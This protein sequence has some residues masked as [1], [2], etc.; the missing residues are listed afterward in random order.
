MLVWKTARQRSEC[1]RECDCDDEKKRLLKVVDSTP[2]YRRR[3]RGFGLELFS[4]KR[5]LCMGEQSKLFWKISW[6]AT[7]IG[8]SVNCCVL[9]RCDRP[10]NGIQVNY[11]MDNPP[12]TQGE[13][14]A[15]AFR[16]RN[17]TH[18]PQMRYANFN[19]AL[20]RVDFSFM[21]AIFPISNAAETGYCKIET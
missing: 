7:F 12:T 8:T 18:M 9:G 14:S 1:L 13:A 17:T 15:R 6:N 10:W 16:F 21:T 2:L 5:L 11:G 4:T 19:S 20:S 3:W